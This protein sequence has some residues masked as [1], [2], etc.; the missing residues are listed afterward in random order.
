MLSP[1]R[2]WKF[3]QRIFLRNKGSTAAREQNPE[4]ELVRPRQFID[5][6]TSVRRPIIMNSKEVLRRRHLGLVVV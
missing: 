5:V 1:D 4:F 2:L 3:W 6:D